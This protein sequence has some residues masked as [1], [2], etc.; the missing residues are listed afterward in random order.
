MYFNHFFRSFQISSGFFRF[1]IS[2]GSGVSERFRQSCQLVIFSNRAEFVA[3]NVDGGKSWLSVQD[4]GVA[5]R[6]N[7]R[8]ADTDAGGQ[9][10]GMTHM[11]TIATQLWNDDAGAI[12]ASEYLFVVTILII[13]TIVGLAAVREAV[14]TEL[15]E[16]A[17]ALLA[18]SQGYTISGVQGAGVTIDGSMTIDT[19][20]YVQDP[21]GTPPAIPSLI[22][23]FPGN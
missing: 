10:T 18:L 3:R 22:D 14:N 19:P 13:G 2:R 5:G 21:V 12:I 4:T 23:M 6:L 15:G 8:R 20:G 1:G 7:A 17:N 9:R 11:K 16:V